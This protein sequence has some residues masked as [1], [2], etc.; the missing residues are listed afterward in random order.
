M[1]F[2]KKIINFWKQSYRTDPFAFYSE[3]IS[4][5]SVII[6]SSILTYTVLNPRPDIFVPFYF[7]GSCFGFLG[8]YRRQ[9]AWVMVLTTWFIAMNSIALYRLFL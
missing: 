1:I 4:A 2:L 8:A 9:A 3:M 6:G 5:I 7:I